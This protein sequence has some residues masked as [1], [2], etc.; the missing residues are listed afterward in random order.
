MLTSQVINKLQEL[1]NKEGDKEFHIFH[2]LSN[3][4]LSCNAGDIQYDDI[5]E[6]I[7]IEVK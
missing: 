3:E 7:F 6:D 4:T 1:V 2:Y 5:L